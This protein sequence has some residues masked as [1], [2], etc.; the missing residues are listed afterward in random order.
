MLLHLSLCCAR[1]IACT[2]R[3]G[4]QVRHRSE[5]SRPICREASILYYLPYFETRRTGLN[6]RN[7][8][9]A[10][11]RSTTGDALARYPSPA[12]NGWTPMNTIRNSH[13]QIQIV[14]RIIVMDAERIDRRL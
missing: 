8:V 13:S 9:P 2:Q 14:Q 3:S 12:V 11:R 10:P 6:E 7:E 5:T 1:L 4:A